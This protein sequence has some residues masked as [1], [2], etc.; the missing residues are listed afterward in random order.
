[1]RYEPLTVATVPGYVRG[2]PLMGAVFAKDE[3][4]VADDLADGNVNLVF[5]VRSQEEPARSVILKQALPYARAVGTAFPM[6]L[7]R[8]DLERR[9]LTV[10]A[11][12]AG[13]AVPAL[14]H[15]DPDMHLMAIEDLTP[16]LI[17]REGLVRG[18]E[19]PHFAEQIGEFMAAT[20]FHTSD[21]GVSSAEK[22]QLVKDFTNPRLTGVTEDLVFTEPFSN[23][24][25]NRYNRWNPHLA[26]IV[27]SLWA[28]DELAAAVA[29]LKLIF[30]THAEALIHGDLHTGSLMVTPDETRVID[31][32]FGFVGPMAF[33]LGSLLGNLAL[34][35]LAQDGHISDPTRRAAY[36]RWIAGAM[37]HLWVVFREEFRGRWNAHGPQWAPRAYQDH[38]FGRLLREAAGFAG[39]EMIR[40]LIGLAHAL[41]VDRIADEAERAVVEGKALTLA[42]RWVVERE[43]MHEMADLL[44]GL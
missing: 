13:T 5:R 14:Y 27:G 20:L 42:R 19:Y 6:P 32:E 44:I 28:D 12:W 40:R 11:R 22:K 35:Y 4:L 38:Y 39:V 2:T 17:M 30:M 10:E 41:E 1:M 16:H 21:L 15:Y 8:I 9:M 29:D 7:E 25:N 33:D 31:P 24:P 43:H 36:R 3:G 34:A 18:I 23:H 26:P 37:E